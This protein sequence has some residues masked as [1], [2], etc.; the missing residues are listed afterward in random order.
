MGITLFYAKKILKKGD[1]DW[2]FDIHLLFDGREFSLT[3]TSIQ[4]YDDDVQILCPGADVKSSESGDVL[5][6]IV[7]ISSKDQFE[8]IFGYGLTDEA[9]EL[10]SDVYSGRLWAAKILSM[11]GEISS[12]SAVLPDL[13]YEEVIKASSKMSIGYWVEISFADVSFENDWTLKVGESHVA[14]SNIYDGFKPLS[15]GDLSSLIQR[16]LPVSQFS[17]RE[18]FDSTITKQGNSLVLKVTDQ[19]RRM[20]LDVGDTVSVTMDREKSAN[21]TEIRALFAKNWSPIDDPDSICYKSGCDLSKVKKFLNDFKI[22]GTV[23]PGT[24]MEGYLTYGVSNPMLYLDHLSFLKTAS[25][26]NIIVSQ[27]YLSSF[28]RDGLVDWCKM[29]GCTFEEF[30]DYSWHH[31][32]ETTL[33]VIRR[34]ENPQ[35]SIPLNQSQ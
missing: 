25:G 3:D 20:G 14:S 9:T 19:C 2:H 22:I 21:N 26:E 11:S 24:F 8:S 32:P 33:I 4:V 23:N 34:K 29:Y 16:L 31:P 27:P 35:W 10:L 12:V 5:T 17:C 28:T 13:F 6:D 7:E 30:P 15:M 18:E 1:G